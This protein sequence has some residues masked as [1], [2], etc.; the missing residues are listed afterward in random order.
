[1]EKRGGFRVPGKVD[2]SKGGRLGGKK[3]KEK[4]FQVG[5]GREGERTLFFGGG[6]EK[7]RGGVPNV[8]NGV[9]KGERKCLLF[10]CR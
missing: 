6:N 1:M 5:A 10:R 7:G 3:E 2:T 9:P 4:E 8:G